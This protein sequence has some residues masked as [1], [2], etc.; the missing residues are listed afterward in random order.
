ML[1]E[2]HYSVAFHAIVGIVIAATIMI[3]PFT[4]FAFSISQAVINFICLVVGIIV[5]LVLD[6]FNSSVVKE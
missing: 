2:K 5:A 4:S 6:K 3:I 1:F